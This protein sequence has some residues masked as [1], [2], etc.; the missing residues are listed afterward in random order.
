[1]RLEVVN[2]HRRSTHQ[3]ARAQMLLT[4]VGAEQAGETEERRQRGYGANTE[5]TD[6]MPVSIS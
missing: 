2:Q 5:P 6:A 4:F 1:M 3:T